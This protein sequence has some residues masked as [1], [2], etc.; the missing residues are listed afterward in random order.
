MMKFH[1]DLRDA[2]A[3]HLFHIDFVVNRESLLTLTLT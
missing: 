3:V 2:V 1:V